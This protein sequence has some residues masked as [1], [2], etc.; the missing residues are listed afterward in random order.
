MKSYFA[1]LSSGLFLASGAQAINCTQPLATATE[2]L[3]CQTPILQQLDNE[4]NKAYSAQKNKNQAEQKQWLDSRNRCTSQTCLQEQ[5]LARINR[6]TSP[7][8]FYFLSNSSKKLNIALTIECKHR[9]NWYCEGPANIS[10][11]NKKDHKASQTIRMKNLFVELKNDKP[12]TNL[13]EL[14]GENNS[15]I[16]VDDF[17]FDGNEDLALRN[18][19]LGSYGGPSYDIYLFSPR[20]NQFTRNDPLT[21]LASSNLG[22]FEVNPKKKELYTLT[23]SGCCWH[24][25]SEYKIINDKPKKIK[26]IT[27]AMTNDGK[28]MEITTEKLINGKW[29]AT[30]KK[31]K[32][33]E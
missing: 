11:F 5:Y 23:K 1:F 8:Q 33:T 14:Y 6:L 12:S 18:G 31:V 15:G 30:V 13:I 28:F 4:L 17:N 27:E 24:Q 10:L 9:D 20:K 3:I 7:K 22:L 16:V 26:I 21:E 2:K 29:K 25:S 32:I 19:N